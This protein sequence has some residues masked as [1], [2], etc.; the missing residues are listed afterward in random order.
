MRYVLIFISI[1]L[2]AGCTSKVTRSTLSGDFNTL[3][4]QGQQ[5]PDLLSLPTNELWAYCQSFVKSHVFTPVDDCFT[6]IDQRFAAADNTLLYLVQ[7]WFDTQFIAP[8]AYGQG[9]ITELRLEAAMA[10][11]NTKSASDLAKSLYN[12]TTTYAYPMSVTTTDYPDRYPALAGYDESGYG[13]I[14]RLKHKVLALGTLGLLAARQGNIQAAN[15]YA[16]EI[17]M[18]DASSTN[19]AQW[20]LPQAKALWLGRIY[21]TL[22]DYERAYQ[23]SVIEKNS[24][25]ELL[26]GLS[27][28]L[29][30]IGPFM[31]AAMVDAYGD[32]DYKTALNF[33]YEFEPRFIRH[34]AELET[35]RLNDAKRGY[36]AIISE[37]KVKGFGT[38][39]WQALHGLGRIAH[40]QGNTEQA[41]DF[42]E[43]AISVIERQRKSVD[44]EAG[45]IGFVNDKQ[46]A[47][48]DMIAL[49]ISQGREQ[50]AF[51]YAERA[52]A[53]ALVDLLASKSSFKAQQDTGVTAAL[54]QF[55]TLD[56]QSFSRED[57]LGSE[58][59]RGIILHR[60][61]IEQQAPA[62]AALVTVNEPSLAGIQ[63]RLAPRETMLVYYYG[64]GSSNAMLYTFVITRDDISSYSQPLS[65]LASAVS[66]L[67]R[68]ISD[69]TGE[70]WKVPS[71]QLYE[72]LIAPVADRMNDVEKLTIVPHGSLHYL[73]FSTLLTKSDALLNEQ[74]FIRLLPSAS[75]LEYLSEG[76]P[77]SQ[78]LTLA[79]P[80][81]NQPE[82]DLPGAQQEATEIARL[83][84]NGQTYL[85]QQAS[86][87]LLKSQAGSYPY[88]HLASHG[89]FDTNNPLQSRLYL[90]ADAQNDGLLTVPEIYDLTL[91]ARLV[92][93]SA[94]ETG[95]GDISRGDDVIGLNRGFLF[96]GA[97]GIVSSLWQVPDE[98]T[99]YL[100]TRFYH[101]LQATAPDEALAAAQRDARARYPHPYHWAAFQLTGE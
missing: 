23:A 79:N 76:L 72:Q 70:Q 83:W 51:L 57:G 29:D 15:D 63:A 24:L 11:G 9:M 19:A 68:A 10:R 42:Y 13:N 38:V 35:G 101:H 62:L 55:E 26:D 37:P 50:Q 89:S 71:R 14:Y 22:G 92:V 12:L 4:E 41:F 48:A 45:R 64:P 93:L 40:I 90:A 53:R 91:Q 77:G 82:L 84:P 36:E 43:Q 85:R 54:Q 39:Y 18:I 2:I 65:S 5:Q 30:I 47:Y 75:V 32:T 34:Q 8:G 99:T 94:C 31:Y 20:R 78:L 74:F 6:E 98:S 28:A 61:L 66:A 81:L 96:A 87:T 59:T 86:E 33:T 60:K 80:D 25:Y 58:A 100:M 21:I 1:W 95:I 56:K 46:Q 69:G 52:K 44:S 73:P 67:R 88:I 7:G 27:T 3:A 97:A 16:D 49:L 17:A